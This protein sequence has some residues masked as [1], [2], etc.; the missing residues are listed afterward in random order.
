MPPAFPYHLIV[1]TVFGLIFFAFLF[2]VLLVK[3]FGKDTPQVI[4]VKPDNRKDVDIKF[5]ALNDV[6]GL[7]TLPD[8]EHIFTYHGGYIIVDNIVGIQFYNAPDSKII[9]I[10]D[11]DIYQDSLF[12]DAPVGS[13]YRERTDYAL[14]EIKARVHLNKIPQKTL[15]QVEQIVRQ[16]DILQRLLIDGTIYQDGYD[17]RYRA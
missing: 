6:E 16:V 7:I 10:M 4:E 2:L 12:T 11:M 5:E 15:L 13:S 9:E 8:G 3:L 1:P 14:K 17:Y